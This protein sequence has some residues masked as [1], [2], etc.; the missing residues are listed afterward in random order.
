LRM[1]R[2][3]VDELAQLIDGG[4]RPVILDVRPAE[5]RAQDGIIP[6]AVTAHP[7]EIETVLD[8]YPRDVE[9][10]IYCACPN[11]ATAAIAANHL[12]RAGYRKIRPLLGGIDAWTSTGRPLATLARLIHR[13]SDCERRV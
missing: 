13:S 10:I 12:K 11:E 4:K 2:I 7:T 9:I 8:V 5:A 6:G 1:D 3:S